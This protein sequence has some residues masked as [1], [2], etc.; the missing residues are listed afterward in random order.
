[1]ANTPKKPRPCRPP[2][3]E[4]AEALARDFPDFVKPV[5]ACTTKGDGDASDELRDD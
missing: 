3:H 4:E 5:K 2:T 1:M